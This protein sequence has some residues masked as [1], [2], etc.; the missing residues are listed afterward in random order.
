MKPETIA[1]RHGAASDP[2]HRAVTPPLHL[3]TTFAHDGWGGKGRFDYARTANPTRAMLEEALAALEGGAGAV[4]TASG[5]AAIDLAFAG[6]PVGSRIVA[7][8][9]CYGGTWRLLDAHRRMGRLDVAFVDQHDAAAL[10]ASLAPGVAMVLIETPSNPLMRVYDIADIAAQA[11]TAGA[12][13]LVDNTFLSPALQRPLGLGADLVVHSTTKFLNGHSDVIGG[14]LIAATA[15]A[16]TELAWWANCTGVGGAPFDSYQTLRGLRTLFVR[17]ERAQATAARLAALLAAHPAVAAVHWPG[18]LADPG[19][20]L[21]ARQQAGFGAV[22]SFELRGGLEAA[23]AVIDGV[24][25]LIPAQSLGGVET[26]ISHPAT[27]THAGM[28]PDARAS[29]GIVDGLLRI[30]VGLEAPCDL[31]RDLAAALGEAQRVG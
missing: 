15:E 27:M 18:L 14:V 25:L 13:V 10:A 12:R 20:A 17:M 11:H 5:M 24:R 16:H 4:V 22:L 6:L 26:L 29:A 21:A 28:A 1:A 30:S 31:E 19:H 2:A 8:H 9:D 23:R 7:P 3:S